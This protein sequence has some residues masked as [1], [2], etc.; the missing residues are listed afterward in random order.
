MKTQ[1]SWLRGCRRTAAV[2]LSF[3]ILPLAEGG[4]MAPPP[5]ASAVQQLRQA[6][7][8]WNVT[9]TRYGA[10]GAIAAVASGTWHFDWVVPDRVLSGRAVIPDWK[11][12][13]GMLFYLN[14]RRSTLEMASVGADGQ[15]LVM[16]GPAGAETR[17]TAAIPLPDGRR[18][19]QRYTRYGITTDRF[20]TRM[21]TSH[22]GGQSWKAGHHQ[23]FVRAPANRA[24]FGNRMRHR[25]RPQ[26]YVPLT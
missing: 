12:T 6:A 22:D 25:T 26:P 20:E 7:G 2:I 21:E 4:E 16:S 3:F 15:L 5:L 18:M 14:E 13:A 9:T 24:E 19:L 10:N 1:S 23:L 8:H 17:T 11:Q